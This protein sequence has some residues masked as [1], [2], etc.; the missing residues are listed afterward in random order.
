[1]SSGSLKELSKAITS[2]S[3]NLTVPLPD[4]LV[5]V[6]TAFLEKHHAPEES[7]SQRLQEELFN[8]YQS[9]FLEYPTRLAP[10]L[11]ILSTLRPVLRGSGR[12]L[13]WWDKLST[14]V[15]IHM[16]V[17]KGLAIEARDILL[18]ILVY[19]EEEE[20]RLEDAQFTSD[21]VADSL[22]ATWLEKTE[23]AAGECD[24]HAIFLVKQIQDILIAFGKRRPKDF[25][26]SIDKVIVKKSSR[27]AGLS[28]LC[29]FF[30]HQPPH[31]HQL[32][33]T[34][35]FENL[36]QCLQIDT[37]TRV[38][39]L[40]IT[41][42]VMFLPHI[43][44]S[45]SKHLPALFNIYS[46][47][48]FWDRERKSA[49]ILPRADV[50][51]EDESDVPEKQP[52]D[53]GKTWDKLSFL[54]ESED[55][56]VPELLHYF[57]FLYGLYPINFMSYIRKPQRYLRHANFPGADDLDIEP[58]QI[59]Q[60][61]E[62]FRQ[63]HLLHPNFFTLTIESEIMGNNRWTKSEAADVVAECIALFVP[64]DEG[65][66]STS[67][68]RG[69]P[70][71]IEPNSDI[72]DQ[73]LLDSDVVTPYQSRHTSWRNTQST[74]VTS[75]EVYRSSGLHRK[76]SQ[77][78]QSIPSIAD[79][80]SFHPSDRLDSPTLPPQILGSPSNNR[81]SDMLSS[82]STRGSLYQ[83]L[84]NDSVGSLS[85]SNN[86]QESHVDAYL[87]SLSRDHAPR[88][89]SLRPTIATT[90]NVPAIKVAYLQREIQLLKNDLN[91]ERYLKQQHLSHIKRLRNKQIREARAEAETQ[92]LVNSNRNLKA[93]L[94]EANRLN[95][96]MKKEHEK[97][98]THSR[99][100]ESE[101][102][103]KIRT[104]REE[105]KKWNMEREELSR[106]LKDARKDVTRLKNIVVESESR[107][108]RANQKVASVENS[109]DELERLRVEV[110]ELQRK[111]VKLEAGE[112][113]AQRAMENERDAL[114][115][116]E[117]LEMELRAR[118]LE[119]ENAHR[120]FETELQ[121]LL[122]TNNGCF[123][124]DHENRDLEKREETMQDVIDKALEASR[125]RNSE[126]EKVHKHLLNRYNTLSAAYEDSLDKRTRLQYEL[127]R[128]QMLVHGRTLESGEKLEW[129]LY[130]GDHSLLSGGISKSGLQPATPPPQGFR[131][132]AVID[133][134]SDPKWSPNSGNASSIAP[135]IRP[136]K[137]ITSFR[138]I[139][140]DRTPIESPR[141]A[142]HVQHFQQ[143]QPFS[144]PGTS[145]TGKASIETDSGSG[146]SNTN[147]KT[148]KPRIV[149]EARIHGRGGV[150]NVGRKDI[151]PYEDINNMFRKGKGKEMRDTQPETPEPKK[152][153]KTLGIKGI[154]GFM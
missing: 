62:P 90:D 140:P 138:A 88:S 71:K 19:D 122:L 16:G 72:P 18:E 60:R 59:R 135:P 65:P 8:V 98:K 50:E 58:A 6:I 43:P 21:A 124:E 130:A 92:N 100:W 125:I 131:E 119:I 69:P 106:D 89:P 114:N 142:G 42:L 132:R 67:R 104:L 41:A 46:R 134:D 83:A 29:D 120:A 81:L 105:S 23:V 127:E 75:P 73:P 108:L 149:P 97:S 96:Q 128:Y 115:Q 103:V 93:K 148:K 20:S 146:E 28:L 44:I 109:L 151:D 126:H 91:F 94:E 57:T 40:A 51:T 79:S 129:G 56:T 26:K 116:I 11:R 4:D 137:L 76:L 136:S 25:L 27:I 63:V 85:L 35:L 101:L 31:L 112:L 2:S 1:M 15:M 14:P 49:D 95:L 24:E 70:N 133:S 36:L 144:P 32:L 111:V 38:I 48:L 30:R 153:K 12:S 37:S 53:S 152:E 54:L 47:L 84:T 77:T 121:H 17:E 107:E 86:H 82:K 80:P 147:T 64:S 143:P 34:P 45:A 118:D 99:K 61:S 117:I 78:S 33:Q 123:N 110:E 9:S 22:L 113:A 141:S 7:D 150:Q 55:D 154:R 13:Q 74:A 139:S 68:S 52:L 10:F 145:G 87:E 66:Q 102:T 39:S 3:A 5:Q